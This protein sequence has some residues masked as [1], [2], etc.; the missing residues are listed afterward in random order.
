[1][2]R[3]ILEKVLAGGALT[4]EEA[5]LLIDPKRT[6]LDELTQA[7]GAV[8]RRHFGNE[9]SMCA[10][11][12][13]KVGLCSGDCAFC[14]QSAR[15]SADIQRFRAVHRPQ[16]GPVGTIG[17]AAVQPRHERRALNRRGV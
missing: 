17:R 8:T 6:P 4:I 16:R 13:A 10:I 7:A 12:P 5:N 15:H 14:A 2:M 9:I 1:M 3:S 11:Y